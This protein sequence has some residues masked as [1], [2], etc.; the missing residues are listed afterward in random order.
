[1]NWKKKSRTKIFVYPIGFNPQPSR[2]DGIGHDF[3]VHLCC[4][5]YSFYDV[6]TDGNKKELTLKQFMLEYPEIYKKFI[7]D[8]KF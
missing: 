8:T 1:M 5:Q 4:N 3:E 2:D 6:W 7:K